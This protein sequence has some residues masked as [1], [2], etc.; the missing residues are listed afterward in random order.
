MLQGNAD[1]ELSRL[2]VVNAIPNLRKASRIQITAT[3]RSTFG[4]LIGGVHYGTSGENILTLLE[5]A[6]I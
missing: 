4:I 5:A 6:N 3:T 1:E 2:D